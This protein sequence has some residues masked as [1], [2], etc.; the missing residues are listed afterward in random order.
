MIEKLTAWLQR[1][2]TF[3][4]EHRR[5]AVALAII[6]AVIIISPIPPVP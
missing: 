2:F 3:L 5:L 6:L 1:T 4:R